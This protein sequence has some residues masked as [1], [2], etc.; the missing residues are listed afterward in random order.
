MIKLV[1]IHG[2]HS[3]Q[4][5]NHAGDS[6]EEIIQTYIAKGFQWV[7][8]T[9][10]MPPL[11]DSF[12]Y[13]EEKEAGFNAAMLQDRFGEYIKTCRWLQQKYSSSI[14]IYLGVETEFYNNVVPFIEKLR[15]KFQPDFLVGSVH[16]VADIPFDYSPGMYA[17]ALAAAGSIEALYCRYFDLQYEML[18]S[19]RPA[20][21]GHF[22]LIRIY[23]NEYHRRWQ[24]PEIINRIKR[25]L[26]FVRER[27]LILDFNL[28]AFQ[29]GDKEPYISKPLLLLARDLGIKIVPGDDS[30]G[31]DQV[32]LNI[33]RAIKILKA[34]GISDKWPRP[35]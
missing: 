19:L 33:S 25:N 18:K 26:E 2:G 1:S 6:L 10:H 7:G 17:K 8:I 4:F 35:V 34:V 13:P 30:H 23:D 20:V 15:E 21:V 11:K 31:K 12:L 27:D 28:R 3:G 24:V 32:G 29:K 5:C 14:T 22:D 16:H 9:E